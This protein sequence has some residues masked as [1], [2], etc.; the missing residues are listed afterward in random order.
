MYYSNIIQTFISNIDCKGIKKI[1]CVKRF[2][3]KTVDF[4]TRFVAKIKIK[5]LFH[6]L[7]EK[8]P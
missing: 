3:I 2:D 4:L 6:T 7:F 8:C 5:H 1:L